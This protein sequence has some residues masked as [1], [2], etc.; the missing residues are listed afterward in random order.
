M[1]FLDKM[2]PPPPPPP[3][4]LTHCIFILGMLNLT[5]LSLQASFKAEWIL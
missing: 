1:K 2:P 3:I 5:S 4:L